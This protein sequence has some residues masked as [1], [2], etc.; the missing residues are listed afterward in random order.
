MYL[1]HVSL[2]G[3]QNERGTKLGNHM[4]LMDSKSIERMMPLAKC[5]AKGHKSD[6]YYVN[7]GKENIFDLFY[8]L[9]I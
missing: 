4:E 6:C 8:L 5:F 9:M 3:N 1:F 7:G 2:R